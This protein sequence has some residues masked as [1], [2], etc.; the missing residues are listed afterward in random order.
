[1][2]V[3]VSKLRNP[4]VADKPHGLTAV[5]HALRLGLDVDRAPGGG[6]LEDTATG[7]PITADSVRTF[8]R[9]ISEKSGNEIDALIADL[10]G[11]R[12]RLTSDGS[13]IEEQIIEYSTLNHSVLKLAEV[14]SDSVAQVKAAQSQ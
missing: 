14:V 12:E 11:L 10:R 8:L 6:R 5:D 4:I 2:I 13:R 3:S 7:T 1:L 9:G